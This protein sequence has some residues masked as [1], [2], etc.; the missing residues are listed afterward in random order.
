MEEVACIAMYI[1]LH[2]E[3]HKK[4]QPQ[5]K[6]KLDEEILQKFEKMR[7]GEI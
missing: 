2:I 3:L 1:H 4:M 5:S 6:I 7:R